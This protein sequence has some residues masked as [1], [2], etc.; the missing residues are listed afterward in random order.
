M[1]LI[2]ASGSASRRA[3]LQSAGIDFEVDPADLDEDALKAG[4][5][6]DLGDLA[7]RLAEEKALAVSRRRPGLVLGADQ[8]LD[9]DGRLFDKAKSVEEAEA[10]LRAL[11]GRTHWLKGAIAAARDGDIIW[12]HRSACRM[13]MRDFSDAFLSDY[14]ARAGDILTK[15]V[16]AY[17]YEGLG[18]QL[19]E[20]VE[21][22]YHAVLGLDL[23]PVLALLREQGEAPV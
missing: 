17:A 8:V 1:T 7:L 9:H 5:A 19:F 4:F 3:I 6:G 23:L 12:R 2:L 22:D 11:R 15:G 14:L 10:K 18:A 21:G 20:R 16:G 13:V